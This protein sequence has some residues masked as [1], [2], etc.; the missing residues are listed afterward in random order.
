M[1]EIP[2]SGRVEVLVEAG[3]DAIWDVVCDVT[4]VGEW[5]HE[6]VGAEWVGDT[7]VATPGARF[8]GRNRSGL[9]R[10]GR[11][12]EILDATPWTLTW[13]TVP[14]VLYPDSTEWTIRLHPADSGTRIEQSFRVVKKPPRPLERLYA[15]LIPGHLDRTEALTADLRRL[16]ACAAGDA[17]N[18]P[19]AARA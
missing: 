6:C 16:G 11:P 13:R 9:I 19:P 1:P 18:R 3:R 2:T 5:S 8:R 14:S 7:R 4:R 12:C 17:I 10:W 15:R